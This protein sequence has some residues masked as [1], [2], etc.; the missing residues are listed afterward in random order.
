MVFN[1][2]AAGLVE[3]LLACYV[4]HLADAAEL[5]QKIQ[6]MAIGGSVVSAPHNRRAPS[7][8]LQ[9]GALTAS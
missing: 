2:A 7:S 9:L 3:R 1:L 8:G 5:R 6:F 4:R